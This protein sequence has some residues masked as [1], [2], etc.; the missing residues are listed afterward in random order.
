MGNFVIPEVCPVCFFPTTTEG[1]FLYC[2]NRLCP[3]RLSGSIQVW[4]KQLGLLHWG[5]ALVDALTKPDHPM[6]E[7]V[8]DLYRLTVA[9]LTKCCSGKKMAQKCYDILHA[10][11]NITLELLIASVNIPNLGISTATD[12]VQAGFNTVNKVLS[13][14]YD[15]LIKVPNIGD[16]TAKQILEGLESKRSVINELSQV[17]NI[18]VP[19]TNG[20]LSGKSFCI[21]G[22]LSKPR[23]A[24]QKMI[25]DAGG[26]A[27]DSVTKTL[28][29]LVTN[30]SSTNS[31]K[32]QKAKK[33]GIPI[34]NESDLNN[35][36]GVI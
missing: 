33:L 26:V 31:G 27:K 21:T 29:Y 19:N 32:M 11:K 34:I 3:A 23:K 2:R 30:D 7:S 15:D 18:V 16:V 25:M 10:N 35:M 17:L 12:I 24:V 5:D 14:T 1:D 4:I 13:L 36:L 28:S 20:P 9:D 8:A 6:I 22:D